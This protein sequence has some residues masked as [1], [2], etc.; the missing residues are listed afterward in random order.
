MVTAKMVLAQTLK[1]ISLGSSAFVG[2]RADFQLGAVIEIQHESLTVPKVDKDFLEKFILKRLVKFTVHG[3]SGE[4]SEL[5]CS[6][7]NKIKT[8]PC[9]KRLFD[10]K[11][12]YL[13]LAGSI[14]SDNKGYISISFSYL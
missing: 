10:H 5:K 7:V 14:V 4:T 13:D 9:N 1:S 12:S 2:V 11:R 8:F 6:Y 3:V